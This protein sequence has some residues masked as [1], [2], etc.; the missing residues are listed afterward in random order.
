[1]KLYVLD[2]SGWDWADRESWM[3]FSQSE[4]SRRVVVY[5]VGKS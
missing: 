1:M 4:C 3:R 5:N 2:L